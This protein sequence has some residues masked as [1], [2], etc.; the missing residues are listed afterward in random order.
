MADT[1]LTSLYLDLDIFLKK[2]RVLPTAK[3]TTP[4]RTFTFWDTKRT[5]SRVE[6]DMLRA[7]TS[8]PL[9]AEALA[10]QLGRDLQCTQE[11]LEALV[12]IGVLEHDGDRYDNTQAT[13]LYC[14]A[15][16]HNWGD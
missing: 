14:Q 8:G 15:L 6:I 9:C 7:L 13:H 3:K 2:C 1:D 10:T 4:E 12:D 5:L 16:H 11:V